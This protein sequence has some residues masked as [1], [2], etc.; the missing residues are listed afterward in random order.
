MCTL[1]RTVTRY[2]I[3]A[4]TTVAFAASVVIITARAGEPASA[5][6]DGGA[7]NTATKEPEVVTVGPGPYPGLTA[8]E[9]AKWAETTRNAGL[10]DPEPKAAEIMTAVPGAE[11]VPPAT[12]VE[13]ERP[14]QSEE[15]SPALKPPVMEK[16]PG[17]PVP[18]TGNQVL[19]PE[20]LAKLE[21]II[22][23]LPDAA[24]TGDSTTTP[25]V[26]PAETG[27]GR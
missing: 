6:P 9:L 4:A 8:A 10:L 24:A 18:T 3:L 1:P 16:I 17:P 13:P 2:L 20:E 22:Q 26:N 21:R 27:V 11:G 25:S 15:A 7:T 5:G 14:G 23:S 19:T 12:A